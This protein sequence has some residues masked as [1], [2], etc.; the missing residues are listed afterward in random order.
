MNGTMKYSVILVLPFLVSCASKKSDLTGSPS[1]FK[2]LEVI[3]IRWARSFHSSVLFSLKK[4]NG[5]TKFMTKV[6]KEYGFYEVEQESVISFKEEIFDE[7]EHIVTSYSLISYSET[8]RFG[9]ADGSTWI[10]GGEKGRF[11]FSFSAWS[12]LIKRENN[13]DYIHPMG[14]ICER[15]LTLT[16]IHFPE[17]EIY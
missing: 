15:I 14:P 5:E 8:D 12:P 2:D 3:N 10:I 17:D 6:F 16:D 4:E 9:G 13:K 7:I 11:S 1:F